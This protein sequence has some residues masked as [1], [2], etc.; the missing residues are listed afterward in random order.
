[1]DLPD[2]QSQLSGNFQHVSFIHFLTCLFPSG[3]FRDIFCTLPFP[4]GFF[5]NNFPGFR[6]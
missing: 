6:Q 5:H 1:L 3:F 4:Q 2:C